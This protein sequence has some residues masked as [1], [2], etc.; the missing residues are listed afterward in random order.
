MT[1][2]RKADFGVKRHALHFCATA[3][4]A[5]PFTTRTLRVRLADYSGLRTVG[6]ILHPFRE[7]SLLLSSR[8]GIISGLI[9]SVL[10]GLAQ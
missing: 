6:L 9:P 7:Q 4:A 10:L 2:T 3:R 1:A 5:V 8:R